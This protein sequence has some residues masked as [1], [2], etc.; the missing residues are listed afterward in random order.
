L[1]EG[2]LHFQYDCALGRMSLTIGSRKHGYGIRYLLNDEVKCYI[3]RSVGNWFHAQG[4]AMLK[5][6]SPI[7]RRIVER[8]L[9]IEERASTHY[10]LAA[11][12]IL[13]R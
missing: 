4:A 12:R 1:I 7:F 11:C 9:P 3:L 6:L 5:S 13:E 10:R 8:F 2:Q